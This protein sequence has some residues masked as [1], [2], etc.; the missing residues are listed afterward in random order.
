[1][2]LK[3]PE[4]LVILHQAGKVMLDGLKKVVGEE[5]SVPC[6]YSEYGNL[7]SSSI[8]FLLSEN[9]KEFNNSNSYYY[10]WFWCWSFIT[11]ISIKKRLIMTVSLL[12]LKKKIKIYV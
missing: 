11:Y 2:I 10:V 3:Y 12:N 6:N 5:A 7:V 4:S 9:I 8:P 1:M